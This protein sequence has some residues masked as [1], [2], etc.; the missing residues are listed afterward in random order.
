[1]RSEQGLFLSSLRT[2]ADLSRCGNVRRMIVAHYRGREAM[3]HSADVHPL[4]RNA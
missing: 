4:G 3:S 1:M 2:T